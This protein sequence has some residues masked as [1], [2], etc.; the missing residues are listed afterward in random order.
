MFDKAE[1]EIMGR[2]VPLNLC[3][4]THGV[5]VD[6]NGHYTKCYVDYSRDEILKRYT[7]YLL[8][9]IEAQKH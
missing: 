1:V 9:L 6:L 5:F 7:D 3:Y 8:E 4:T 2:C